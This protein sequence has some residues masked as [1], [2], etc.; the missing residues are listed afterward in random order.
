MS[1]LSLPEAVARMPYSKTDLARRAAVS[2]TTVLAVNDDP[3]RARVD[4]LRE[5]A[6]ALGYDLS[7][8]LER[9]SDPLA[10]AAA[11][12]MLGDLTLEGQ[13]DGAELEAW[14]DRLNRYSAGESI[15]II[16]EAARLSSAQ[17]RSGRH[18]LA[19]RV[20]ADRLISAGRA[21]EAR[22]VLSGSA[23]LDALG[24]ETGRTVVLWSEHAN[25][26]AELLADTH[27]RV[28]VVTAADLVVAP[29]HATVFEGSTTIEDVNLVSPIQGIIDAFANGG[30][31]REIAESIVRSW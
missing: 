28:R 15:S 9:A 4:T 21:S 2:R 27:R 26:V 20:D 13:K 25:R 11:R 1:E 7:I 22:W 12:V 16:P 23:S 30:V 6:L 10:A 19:G 14:I 8:V 31:D 29:A 17:H 24:A 5:L 18:L 3:S